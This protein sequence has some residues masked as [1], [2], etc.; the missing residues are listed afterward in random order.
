MRILERT[1]LV[2]MS[3][4]VFGAVLLLSC[5]NFAVVD[6]ANDFRVYWKDALRF[7]T[8]GG[9][10][11]LKLGGRLQNDWL[12]WI[13]Q[14]DIENSS[15]GFQ[16]DGTEFRR[17]RLFLSGE[18]HESVFFKMQFDFAGGGADLKDAYLG[19]VLRDGVKFKVGHFKEPFS[20]EELTSSKYITFMERALPNA[21]A[22]SRNTGAALFGHGL[23]ER[24]TWNAGVFRDADDSGE[25]IAEGMGAGARL[26]VL[27]LYRDSGSRLVHLGVSGSYRKTG[28]GTASFAERPEIHLAGDFVDTGDI[29]A[30]DLVLAGFEG[31][32]VGGPFSVQTELIMT[33]LDAPAAHDPSFF[34][35]YVQGSYSLT[36]EHR[37]YKRSSG[38]FG[39]IKPLQY[40]EPGAGKG[41]WEIAGRYSRLD[42][43]GGLVRGGAVSVVTAGINC[44]LNPNAKV[45]LDYVFADV[46]AIGQSHAITARFQISL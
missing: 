22:P 5:L 4:V 3:I 39:N 14:D 34:G 36:G 41:A 21:F 20:L 10:V 46:D 26:T 18:L 37:A 45:M 9:D 2:S 13:Q 28:N 17:A 7:E 43:N 24:M 32:V 40:F 30:D 33:K 16:R 44:Y 1:K 11:K 12:G 8:S 19:I 35:F 38:T 27:P 31:A 23:D 6:A 29:P 15:F 25:S 42:L